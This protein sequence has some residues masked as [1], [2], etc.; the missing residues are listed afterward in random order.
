MYF[1]VSKA[2][3]AF[4]KIERAGAHAGIIPKHFLERPLLSNNIYIILKLIS[5]QNWAW[6][7]I[8]HL[9]PKLGLVPVE[10]ELKLADT[11]IF[12]RDLLKKRVQ[13]TFFGKIDL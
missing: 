4:E 10:G 8:A 13:V 7:E 6:N 3:S 1:V 5:C 12:F 9:I 11:V 2:L